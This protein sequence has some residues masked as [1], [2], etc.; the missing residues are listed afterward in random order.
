MSEEKE[1]I[2]GCD[3]VNVSGPRESDG[4]YRITFTT[5]EYQKDNIA[6]LITLPSEVEIELHVKIRV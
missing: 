3:H 1:I 6:K 2:V 5:G 4:S